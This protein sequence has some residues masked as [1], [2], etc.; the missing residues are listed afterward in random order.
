MWWL[1]FVS[2]VEHQLAIITGFVTLFAV[3]LWIIAGQRPFEILAATAAYAGLLALV[4]Y[5]GNSVSKAGRR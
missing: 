1:D 4:Y 3:A 2:N 5:Q